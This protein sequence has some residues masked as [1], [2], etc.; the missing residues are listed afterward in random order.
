[1]SNIK[2]GMALGVAVL[3]H[4]LVFFV[5]A[6]VPVPLFGTALT[7][8]G[9]GVVIG[10]YAPTTLHAIV[11]PLVLGT[12]T[13]SLYV[14]VALMTGDVGAGDMVTVLIAGGSHAVVLFGGS[15]SGYVA[16]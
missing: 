7:I 9:A 12:L 4:I 8:F 13:F 14:V 6:F 3:L 15:F 10:K 1:M 2:F 16:V 11:T 5:E